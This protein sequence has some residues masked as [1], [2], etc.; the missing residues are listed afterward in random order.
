MSG[1]SPPARARGAK[2]RLFGVKDILKT[3]SW[4]IVTLACLMVGE[5]LLLTMSLSPSSSSGVRKD[6]T[7]P[8]GQPQT[9]AE[10]AA[11][12]MSVKKTVDA[13]VRRSEE[14]F[15]K[16]DFGSSEPRETEKRSKPVS[17]SPETVEKEPPEILSS[18]EVAEDSSMQVVKSNR[19][20]EERP[21][22]EQKSSSSPIIDRRRSGESS[23]S[24][25]TSDTTAGNTMSIA[26]ASGGVDVA[27][28]RASSPSLTSYSAPSSRRQGIVPSISDNRRCL[29]ETYSAYRSAGNQDSQQIYDWCKAMKSR[30]HVQL[31]RSWGTLQ[32]GDRARWD[33]EK[34]NELITL[35]KLQSCN[36]R[37][38]WGSFANW[39]NHTVQ[40]IGGRGGKPSEDA[41]DVNCAIDIKQSTFCRSK[42]VVMDFSKLGSAGPSRSF[43]TG[44]YTTYGDRLSKL[45]K[46]EIPGKLHIPDEGRV[47]DESRECDEVETRPTFVISND[48][49]YNLG[50]YIND[51][52]LVW[53]MAVLANRDTKKSL[54]INIDG[55]RRGG[56]AGGPAHRLMVPSKPDTHGPYL[57]YYASWFEEVKKGVDYGAK[58]VCFRE[59]Y[60]QPFPGVAWF[61]NDWG[62][63]NGCSV[64]AASPL[65]QSFNYF[66]L[67]RWEEAYGKD[68]LLSPVDIPGKPKTSAADSD[69]IHVI[70]EVRSINKNKKNNHSSARFI[71]NLQ[72]LV[73]AL[74]G[75]PNIKVTAQDFAKLSFSDQVKLSHSMGIF[76]SMHGAGTTHI[77]HSAVG[78]RNCCGLVELF[79]DT[80]IE[81]H[82]AHGYGNLARN[83]GFYHDR[84]V[85]KKG[86]TTSS[87]T[88]VDVPAIANLVAKQANQIRAKATCL[89][90]VKD[91]T[92]PIYDR[93]F[94]T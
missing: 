74:K 86:A 75:I 33:K 39:R 58:K 41:S 60:F 49:I 51:V 93:D 45:G 92:K 35:G 1:F 16:L 6:V 24:L 20:V 40:I 31:G 4:A 56:P 26:P 29:D 78:S 79:P 62:Q 67:K 70:I 57:P 68:S 18:R 27:N 44:F 87:G 59:I 34:C 71:K 21:R 52:A 77:F 82:T 85:A 83:H 73:A 65:Y 15:L 84:L 50:H 5:R 88:T 19:V 89:H 7:R 66:L 10:K 37:W 12:A 22:M 32:K 81:F 11:E 53:N 38:G 61:W 63:M 72:D 46:P 23:V 76:M 14:E 48:D 80:S 8:Q 90:D 28:G 47:Y 94:G 55:V 69:I 13:M 17:S 42:R 2:P 64:Q 25:L 91:T 43:G 54:L 9:A 30:H 3:L 36:E